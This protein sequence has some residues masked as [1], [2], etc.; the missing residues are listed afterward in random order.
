MKVNKSFEIIYV[1]TG[2]KT[3]SDFG[4]HPGRTF[5][6]NGKR[7]FVEPITVWKGILV[8]MPEDVEYEQ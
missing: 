5:R 4:F 7:Y 6:L 1:T 8:P 2:K 3:L